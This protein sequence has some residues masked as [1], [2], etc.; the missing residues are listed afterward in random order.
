MAMTIIGVAVAHIDVK[1]TISL[2]N[3]VTSSWLLASIF[4]PLEGK[5][6][7]ELSM[8]M[9][10]RV[11][12]GEACKNPNKLVWASLYHSFIIK[13]VVTI[14]FLRHHLIRPHH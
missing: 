6:L 8:F 7:L 5:M 2:N 14:L 4:S 12:E 10:F 11:Q 9:C 3:I 13:I 1:P